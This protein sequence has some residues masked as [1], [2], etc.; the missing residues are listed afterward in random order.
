MFKNRS[1]ENRSRSQVSTCDCDT[2]VQKGVLADSFF[3]DSCLFTNV[4]NVIDSTSR[5][6]M[7]EAEGLQPQY[8][9]VNMPKVCSR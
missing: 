1:G 9:G 8:I 2:A 3:G 4:L 6:A 5:T 7:E